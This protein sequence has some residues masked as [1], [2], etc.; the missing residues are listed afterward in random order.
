MQARPCASWH[1]ATVSLQ[2]HMPA[3]PP[4]RLHFMN[5]LARNLNVSAFIFSYRGYGQSEGTPSEQVRPRGRSL[6]GGRLG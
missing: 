2:C 5:A 1:R 4:C 6:G 3:A